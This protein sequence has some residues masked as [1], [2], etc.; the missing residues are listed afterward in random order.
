M[1][2]LLTHTA[3]FPNAPYR[4]TDYWD[5]A[6]R[7]KRYRQWRL[8]WEPGTK[9]TYHASSS[10]YVIADVLERVWEDHFESLIS[11]RIAKPLE[12]LEL[13]L[14]CPNHLQDCVA[15]I[16]HCG[17]AMAP[18]EY[19]ALGL[20]EPPVTEV[21]EDVLTKFNEPDTRSVPIPGGGGYASAK[22][23]A[24][25]YQTLIGYRPRPRWQGLPWDEATVQHAREVRTH[26]LRDPS[27]GYP[28][29]RGLGIVI[30]GKEDAN[31]RGFGHGVSDQTFGHNGAGGQI[32]WVDPET[33]LSFVYLTNGH[34][35]DAIRQA[36]RGIALSSLAAKLAELSSRS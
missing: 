26:G 35:R 29:L 34:D 30:A 17:D 10:M 36:R 15:D 13:L 33:E 9:F 1:L 25:W 2:H 20:E 14:G 19:A 12:L 7:A 16:V 18:E 21:T 11:E 31:L 23:L 22:T 3:G 6:K 24:L 28:V 8:D 32:A 4:P 5:P 27:Q